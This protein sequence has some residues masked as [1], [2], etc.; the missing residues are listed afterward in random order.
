MA[1]GRRASKARPA[2]LTNYS[3][4]VLRRAGISYKQSRGG[5]TTITGRT[6]APRSVFPRAR[7]KFL[8][9]ITY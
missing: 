5:R 4:K 7:F 2:T 3:L 8:R 1:N 9:G 6:R